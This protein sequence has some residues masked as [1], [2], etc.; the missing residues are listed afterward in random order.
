MKKIFVAIA[1][2]IAVAVFAASVYRFSRP[3]VDA[4]ILLVPRLSSEDVSGLSLLQ[5]PQVLPQLQFGDGDG[6]V[7]T[8]A[9]F[10]GWATWCEAKIDGAEFEAV[11]LSIDQ[12]RVPDARAFFREVGSW[13]LGVYVDTAGKTSLTLTSLS[14]TLLIDR[15]GQELGQKIEPLK[16]NDPSAMIASN[17][18]VAFDQSKLRALTELRAASI[19]HDNRSGALHAKVRQISA[20][21]GLTFQRLE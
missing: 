17:R 1:G 8:L 21:D 20:N 9:D 2:L 11:A 16:W 7:G 15:R 6:A 10:S 18:A 19:H 3:P 13:D 12:S 4:P 5:H 14:T